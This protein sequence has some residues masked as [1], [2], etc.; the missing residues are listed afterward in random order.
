MKSSQAPDLNKVFRNRATNR[1]I[2]A[3][4]A[5]AMRAKGRNWSD[6]LKPNDEQG[7]VS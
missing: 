3:S 5:R 2:A 6:K 7:N 4:H 1:Q